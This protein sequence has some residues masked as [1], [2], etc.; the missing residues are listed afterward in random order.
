MC[1][2]PSGPQ[3]TLYKDPASPGRREGGK[4]R[5]N[6][7][8][9][10]PDEPKHVANLGAWMARPVGG[11]SGQRYAVMSA[12][13]ADATRP[14]CGYDR[15]PAL[16]PVEGRARLLAC[17]TLPLDASTVAFLCRQGR[18]CAVLGSGPGGDVDGSCTRRFRVSYVDG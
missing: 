7:H 13:R 16:K 10:G 8:S 12:A 14:R 17:V 9:L 5:L 15:S 6:K 2:P 3:A 1:A 4:G 11:M 18:R